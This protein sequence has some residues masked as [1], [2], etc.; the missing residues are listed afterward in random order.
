MK[1]L[2]RLRKKPSSAEAGTHAFL[3]LAAPRFT[4]AKKPAQFHRK[5]PQL[6]QFFSTTRRFPR[7]SLRSTSASTWP[8]QRVDL[9]FLKELGL[10]ALVS[11]LIHSQL[12]YGKATLGRT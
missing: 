1:K 9:S 10:A 4:T 8:E 3:S 6:Q 2:G 11:G 5:E 12:G 7:R